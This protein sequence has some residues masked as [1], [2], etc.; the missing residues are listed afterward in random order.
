M[1]EEQRYLFDTFGSLV[2]PNAIEPADVELL[3]RTLKAPTEQFAPVEQASGPLHWGKEWRDLLDLPVVGPLLE[4][5]VGNP[6][7]RDARLSRHP[8]REPL[9]TFRIDHINVHTHVQKGFPGAK[10][11]G[12]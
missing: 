11:H 1:G 7:F 10:L 3:K 12:G 2:L 5:L 6:D 4:E 8:D 9:P